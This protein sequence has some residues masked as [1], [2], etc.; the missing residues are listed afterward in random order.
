M[1][2]EAAKDVEYNGVKIPKG[3]LVIFPITALQMDPE[4]WP[5]PEKFDPE[6]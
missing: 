4:I 2:R 5:D 6:R 1:D 3:T